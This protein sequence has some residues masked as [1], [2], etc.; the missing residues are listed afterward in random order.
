MRRKLHF[1][2][3]VLALAAPAVRAQ[4]DDP[5]SR[6]ARLSYQSG[7]VAFR[8]GSVEAWTNPALNYPLTTGYHLWTD[9][10]AQTEIH[11]GTAA[12]RMA[13]E[14]A[15]AFLNLDDRAIQL[16][17]TQG[18]IQIHI[19]NLEPEETFE[20]DTPNV[21][22][23]LL[24]PGDYRIDA[25]GD[26]ALTTVT[27]RGGDAAVTGGGIAFPVHARQTARMRGTDSVTEQVG[28][29]LGQDDFERWCESRDRREEQSVSA[30][31]VP[32]EMPGYQDLDDYGN[33]Q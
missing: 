12:I 26:N 17:I 15:L 22:I 9:P 25:D 4:S 5:P 16:S 2:T 10:G 31:Y 13:S 7:S 6:V 3:I 21:A 14:T 32:R 1:L 19:R 30:Q 18:S 27:V 24:R 23:T 20:V 8:P 28:D 33:W 29:A 11:T